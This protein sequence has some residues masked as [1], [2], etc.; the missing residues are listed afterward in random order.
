[1]KYSLVLISIAFLSLPGCG[2][3]A[4]RM[5]LAVTTSTENSGLLSVLLPPF[6]RE[7]GI[8]VDVIAV[9]TGKA[10]RLGENGD[11]D[12]VLV[13]SREAEEVFVG[14]GFGV[15]RHDVM[16]N[17][18]VIAGPSLDPAGIGSVS[19]AASALRKISETESTFVS[20]GD[21]SGT[22]IKERRLWKLAGVNPS[23][24]WYLES[25]QGM[26]PTLAMAQE[27]HAYCLVDRGT[28][29]AYSEGKIDLEILCEGDAEL[30][31]P[32]GIIAVNPARH[33]HVKYEHAAALIRWVTSEEG[34][35][36]IA[37]FRKNGQTLFHPHAVIIEK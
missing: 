5:K 20:R 3:E 12:A 2:G 6:E 31:N 10:L 4:E 33:P 17:D 30:R 26:G 32:Y 24:N 21:D 16:Y 27:K 15:S 34:Q 8:R 1:M 19:T 36:I 9:G 7:H 23:G 14:K 37:G 29:I 13:H 11:V 25:G 35:S 28:Y 22:H 18:F